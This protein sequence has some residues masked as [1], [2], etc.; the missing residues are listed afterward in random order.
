MLKTSRALMEAAYLA[1]LLGVGAA[2]ADE[3]FRS[4]IL[5][6][7]HVVVASGSTEFD[8]TSVGAGD[9]D[10]K[11]VDDVAGDLLNS[12]SDSISVADYRIAITLAD[13]ALSLG[14]VSDERVVQALSTKGT[15]NLWLK[16]YDQAMA[17]FGS[18]LSLSPNDVF[19]LWRRCWA[20][21]A[22]QFY[23]S[24]R[25]DC[26][27]AQIIVE[28]N[29]RSPIRKRDPRLNTVSVYEEYYVAIARANL[30]SAIARHEEALK[31]LQRAAAIIPTLPIEE[32]MMAE[33]TAEV[34]IDLARAFRLSNR[35]KEAASSIEVAMKYAE[36]SSEEGRES[37][38][39]D[40]VHERALLLL[41]SG[42][43]DSA[44]GLLIS[45]LNEVAVVDEEYLVD[46]CSI[47]LIERYAGEVEDACSRLVEL[48]PESEVYL[49][50][51]S[52]V[53]SLDQ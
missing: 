20:A 8:W 52:R 3:N 42:Q 31:Y 14:K 6:A 27:R 37:L 40:V 50:L 13:I 38:I 44:I 21:T 46:T 4:D 17:N 39:S 45:R 41:Q 10:A 9:W 47:G 25:R 1:L 24:A 18:A 34:G 33:F 16:K 32:S 49:K 29:A 35:Y 12:A 48:R 22:L 28:R 51:E 30:E 11:A 36:F 26:E 5:N 43:T 23:P 53:E 2:Q 7:V 15:A 19:L